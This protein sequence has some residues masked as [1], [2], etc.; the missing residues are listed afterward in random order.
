M[1][2]PE[3]LPAYKLG[4]RLLF[5]RQNLIEIEDRVPGGLGIY[6][7]LSSKECRKR[8]NDLAASS[9]AAPPE[10]SEITDTFVV[11][12]PG[13]TPYTI[14]QLSERYNR[15]VEKE[16]I[17]SRQLKEEESI[18]HQRVIRRIQE[19]SE[20]V[21]FSFIIPAAVGNISAKIFG[22]HSRITQYLTIVVVLSGISFASRKPIKQYWNAAAKKVCRVPT[23][24]CGKFRHCAYETTQYASS[25]RETIYLGLSL[26]CDKAHD[27]TRKIS[28]RTL[29]LSAR[30]RD[31]LDKFRRSNGPA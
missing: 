4:E 20:A 16:V 3:A 5:L 13:F 18:Q 22:E 11:Q 19:L 15:L 7:K 12:H 24:L 25:V 31:R 17:L 27:Q 10:T 21:G 8:L 14:K 30:T 1:N 26:Y 29:S 28:Q 23:D 9:A 6:A 2:V